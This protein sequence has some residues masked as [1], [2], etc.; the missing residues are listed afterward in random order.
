MSSFYDLKN[1]EEDSLKNDSK[2]YLNLDYT[3]SQLN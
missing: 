1:S 3:T 2:H